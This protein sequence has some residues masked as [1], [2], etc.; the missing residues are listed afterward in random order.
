MEDYVIPNG[1]SYTHAVNNNRHCG[2]ISDLALK[3]A[4]RTELT[5]LSRNWLFEMI[6]SNRFF[7]MV[8]GDLFCC[9]CC[10]FGGFS[11]G[12]GWFFLMGV[13]L[14]VSYFNVLQNILEV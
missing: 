4:K 2:C 10:L 5:P 11:W 3:L 8:F 6:L 13:D 9:C 7:S 12:F 14:R 1:F